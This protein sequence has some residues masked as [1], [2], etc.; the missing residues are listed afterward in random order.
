[1]LQGCFVNAPWYD[2]K[3]RLLAAGVTVTSDQQS[4]AELVGGDLRAQIGTL[5]KVLRTPTTH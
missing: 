2:L 4:V 5:T 1:M 3:G